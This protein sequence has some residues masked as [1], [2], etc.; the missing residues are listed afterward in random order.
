MDIKEKSKFSGFDAINTKNPQ[1]SIAFVENQW[2]NAE[3]TV[4]GI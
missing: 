1:F 2:Q 3:S 4:K